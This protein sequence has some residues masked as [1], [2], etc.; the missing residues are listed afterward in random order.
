MTGHYFF[1]SYVFFTNFLHVG[2][3]G[4]HYCEICKIR[5][6]HVRAHFC[7]NLSAFCHF[8]DIL[9][10]LSKISLFFVC[11]CVF[12]MSLFIF[13]YLKEI[14]KICHFS[15]FETSNHLCQ[16]WYIF[17]FTIVIIMFCEVQLYLCVILQKCIFVCGR[18][19]ILLCMF[20]CL[21]C[22]FFVKLLWSYTL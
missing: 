1:S 22:S 13:T 16:K 2:S 11:F 20:L 6:I 18:C 9:I 17:L 8:Y 3:N 21:L 14:E 4:T 5:V 12:F 19:E 10:F 15:F 7:L